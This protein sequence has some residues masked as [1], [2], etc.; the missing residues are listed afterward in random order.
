MRGLKWQ[1]LVVL[2]SGLVFIGCGGEGEKQLSTKELEGSVKTQYAQELH[3]EESELGTLRVT[4]VDCVK[5]SDREA[6]CLADVEGALAGRVPIEVTIGEDGEFIYEAESASASLT[7]AAPSGE[8]DDSEIDGQARLEGQ[9]ALSPVESLEG[10]EDAQGI[11]AVAERDGER[12][13]IVQATLPNNGRNEAYQIWLYNSDTD[14]LSLGAQVADQQGNFQGAG[15]LPDNFEDYE[16][17][18]VSRE[19]IRGPEAHSGDS[20]LRGAIDDLAPIP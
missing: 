17:I 6:K 18:D 9:V 13:L 5:K 3:G 20:V 10:S 14:G 16:F 8:I 19:P 4:S 11:A 7:P 1:A 15:P 12:Q 2:A